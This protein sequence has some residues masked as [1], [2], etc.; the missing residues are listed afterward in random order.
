MQDVAD[1]KTWVC[2]RVIRQLS[3]VLKSLLEGLRA[4]SYQVGTHLGYSLD[5]AEKAALDVLEVV[6]QQLIYVLV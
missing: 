5:H 2:A 6:A 3:I 4:L 1:A